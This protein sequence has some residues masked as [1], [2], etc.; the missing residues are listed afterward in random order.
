MLI[1]ILKEKDVRDTYNLIKQVTS[2]LKMYSSE[3][4]K[5]W[6]SYYTPESLA[7]KVHDRKWIL[8]IAKVDGNVVGFSD[9]WIEAGI[10]RSDWTC[11]D[12]VYRRN[13]IGTALFIRKEKESIKRKC[14]KIEADSR[15]N[16]KPGIAFLRSRGFRKSALLNKHWFNQDYYL[17]YKFV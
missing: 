1:E 14:H 16:N 15:T 11:I 2:D 6:L 4:R 10:A 17:W 12:K 8:L 3:A 7:K 9:A 13:G 5:Y